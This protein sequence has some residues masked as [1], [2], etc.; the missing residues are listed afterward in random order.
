MAALKV[1]D[2]V[3]LVTITSF[4]SSTESLNVTAFLVVTLPSSSVEP[5]ALVVRLSMACDVPTVPLKRVT[6]EAFTVRSDVVT[7]PSSFSVDWN[8]TLVPAVSVTLLVS[9]TASE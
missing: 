4:V 8:V 7:A 9:T 1:T 5:A 3:L 2:E 6:P